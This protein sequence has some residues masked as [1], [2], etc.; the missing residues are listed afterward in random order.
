[1]PRLLDVAS[2]MDVS[3]VRAMA[4]AV[5]REIHK[6]HAFVRFREIENAHGAVYIAWF[7][8]THHTLEAAAPFFV[9]RFA[10][11]RWSILT[12]RVSA[13]W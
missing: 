1:E 4:D 5:G 8:P 9:R 13:H 2:D 3:R 12:P 11:M 10:S 6:T 7:E